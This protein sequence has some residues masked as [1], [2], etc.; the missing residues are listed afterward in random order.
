MGRPT[1]WTPDQL[2][3]L[4]SFIPKL[5]QVRAEAGLN[6]LYR[7]IAQEFLTCWEPEPVTKC[8]GTNRNPRETQRAH[9][10]P[11][12]FHMSHFCLCIFTIDN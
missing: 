2:E 12:L 7:T 4:R 3:F 9:G 6:V 5:P 10:D 8:D 1:M 11:T